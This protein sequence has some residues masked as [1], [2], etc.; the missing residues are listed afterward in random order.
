MSAVSPPSPIAADPLIVGGGKKRHWLGT[1]FVIGVLI[2]I[3]LWTLFPFYWAFI[4][5]IKHPSDN[6][7]NKWLPWFTFSPTLDPWREMWSQREV[8]RALTNSVLISFGSATVALVIGTLAAYGIA[9]FQFRRPQNGSLTTWFLSQRILP[10]VIFVTPFFLIMRELGL[11]DT[12]QGLIILN[13]TFN[14]AFPIIILTQM[15]REV[16]KELEEAAQVD[17]ASRF[18]IFY[19]IAVPLVAP[20]IVV[21]WILV[22]AFSWNEFLFAFSTTQNQARPMSVMLVGAE[23][24]RGVDFQFVGTRMITMMA[25][26][27]LASLLVQ[28]YIVRGLSLGAVKG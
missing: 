24:T 14:L 21:S 7:G 9:R 26:P 16:P 19:R 10:P 15:F 6:Y 12:V 2:L 28:R 23:Q 5:S 20:G 17:G 8:R 18:E 11:L 13:A 25:I 3:L 4:N 27:V 22:M 1:I